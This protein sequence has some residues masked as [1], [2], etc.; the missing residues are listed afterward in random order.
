MRSYMIS[1]HQ[2]LLGGHIKQDET[3]G[4]F[5]TYGKKILVHGCR[6]LKGHHERKRICKTSKYMK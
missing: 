6:L 4:E 5:S 1:S 2:T 3:G